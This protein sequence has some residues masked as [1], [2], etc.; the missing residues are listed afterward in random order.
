MSEEH[1]GGYR[2][3]ASVEKEP[4]PLDK[5]LTIS[6]RDYCDMKGT[7]LSEYD[8]RGVHLSS[9]EYLNGRK[10]PTIAGIFAH[11]VPTEA[12][13]VVGYH[14]SVGDTSD[15][16]THFTAEGTALIPKGNINS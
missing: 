2:D 12:E 15:V 11:E 4:F 14:A 7:K 16:F 8:A 3:P 13:I 1:V 9:C 10:D 5:I 6:A